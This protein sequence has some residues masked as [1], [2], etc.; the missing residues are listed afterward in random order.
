MA[1]SSHDGHEVKR[2]SQ[3][4]CKLSKIFAF[5]RWDGL[6]SEVMWLSCKNLAK[7]SAQIKFHDMIECLDE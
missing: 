6:V 5:P 1:I 4:S 2:F 3:F 7:F